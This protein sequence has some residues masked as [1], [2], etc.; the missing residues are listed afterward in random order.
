MARLELAREREKNFLLRHRLR[1]MDAEVHRLQ[2]RRARDEG[3]QRV[4]DAS[5]RT[6][7]SSNSVSNVG[8]LSRHRRTSSRCCSSSRSS[9]QF[10]R[11][12]W[13]SPTY[14]RSR[15]I[16]RPYT[17]SSAR[18][19]ESPRRTSVSVTTSCVH[20]SDD[21]MVTLSSAASRSPSARRESGRRAANTPEAAPAAF[22]RPHSGSTQSPLKPSRHAADAYEA[23]ARDLLTWLLS[24]HSSSSSSS[25]CHP[26]AWRK[27]GAGPRGPEPVCHSNLASPSRRVFHTGL[28]S[29]A[30]AV[31]E[32]EEE[33]G[34]LARGTARGAARACPAIRDSR[35]LSPIPPQQERDAVDC[36]KARDHPTG[37]VQSFSAMPLGMRATRSSTDP[38]GNA[39]FRKVTPAA[40]TGDGEWVAWQ[41]HVLAPRPQSGGA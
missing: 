18:R 12:M 38:S 23:E 1:E 5:K 13:R 27:G 36:E 39:L 7:P 8:V 34:R 3:K 9:T 30:V 21:S 41:P 15:S 26:S 33:G 14:R 37:A 4:G 20:Y 31:S 28:F 6:F 29:A 2:S 40:H 11:D 32:G 16:T 17:S 22:R 25:R 19:E 10:T 24:A 35:L